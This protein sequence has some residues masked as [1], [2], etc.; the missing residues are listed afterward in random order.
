[1]FL[2]QS[3]ALEM[4]LCFYGNNSLLCIKIETYFLTLKRLCKW[5]KSR[6]LDTFTFELPERDKIVFHIK[7]VL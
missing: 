1:M 6:K 4:H 3:N 7:K 5:L 2:I